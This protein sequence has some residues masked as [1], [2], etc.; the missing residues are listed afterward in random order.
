M[1]LMTWRA[2]EGG[3]KGRKTTVGKRQRGRDGR[4]CTVGTAG[5]G[6]RTGGK[7]P[8]WA[9]PATALN[10]L[11]RCL[12]GAV[13]RR[14][15]GASTAGVTKMC[16]RWNRTAPQGPFSFNSCAPMQRPRR[17]RR[18][19]QHL[20]RRPTAQP[21]AQ[22]TARQARAARHGPRPGAAESRRCTRPPT[23]EKTV[24]RFCFS[25]PCSWNVWR[26]VRRSEPLPYCGAGGGG[27]AAC[28]RFCLPPPAA[29][30]LRLRQAQPHD[31]PAVPCCAPLLC[32]LRRASSPGPPAHPSPGTAGWTRTPRAAAQGG[33]TQQAVGGSTSGARE[34]RALGAARTPPLPAPPSRTHQPA[35]TWRVRIM[36]W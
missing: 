36:N 28:E 29:A 6:S 8:S 20:T 5:A 16:S 19:P 18:C 23:V 4:Q 30:P 7:H 24:L 2:G 14:G 15:G 31:T 11:A 12:A 22:C 1:F 25:T 34:R 26:V 21:A 33:V 17:L 27:R 9:D 32:A 35:P 3:K 13:H 10:A